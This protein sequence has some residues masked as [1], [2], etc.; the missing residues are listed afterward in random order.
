MHVD[1]AADADTRDCRPFQPT[2]RQVDSE[3]RA[4][5]AADGDGRWR[6]NAAAA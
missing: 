5:D 1:A 3:S 4:G 6:T 2:L